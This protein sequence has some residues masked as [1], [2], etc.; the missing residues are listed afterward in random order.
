MQT[1]IIAH[2][3]FIAP[4]PPG[5]ASEYTNVWLYYL[6]W[7]WKKDFKYHWL[8]IVKNLNH[9]LILLWQYIIKSLYLRSL[10]KAA[11]LEYDVFAITPDS[12][13]KYVLF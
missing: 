12:F 13:L 8:I 11:S 7:H 2:L 4:K 9:Q 5:I 10:S 1:K 6:N 3:I